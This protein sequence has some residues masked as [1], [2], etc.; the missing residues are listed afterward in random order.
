LGGFEVSCFEEAWTAVAV[1]RNGESVSLRL[2]PL[3]S[4][5]Y[6]NLL[7]QPLNQAGVQK[8]LRSLLEFLA[9]EGRTN[10]NCWAAD[11][12]FANASGWERD[13]V[14]Q[15]LPEDIR[16]ILAKMGEALHDSVQAP[17]IAENFGCLPD[18]LLEKVKLLTEAKENGA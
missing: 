10:A 17:E 16:E 4:D 13:W 6:A 3:L 9:R 8:S 2:R 1:A 12:F 18:Q 11:L 7:T 14:E 15:D 5:V